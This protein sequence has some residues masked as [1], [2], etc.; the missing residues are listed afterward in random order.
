MEHVNRPS[1]LLPSATKSYNVKYVLSNINEEYAD[2]DEFSAL[3]VS[4]NANQR[5]DLSMAI[6]TLL[7]V[8]FLASIETVSLNLARHESESCSRADASGVRV[9]FS[10]TMEMEES[11]DVCY[12]MSLVQDKTDSGY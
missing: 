3:N 8:S 6:Q 1:M 9:K 11:S 7:T 5:I 2:L 4:W 12:V 10:M